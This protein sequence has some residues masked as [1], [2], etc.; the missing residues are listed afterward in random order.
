MTA[1][2]DTTKLIAQAGEHKTMCYSFVPLPACKMCGSEE[3]DFLGLRLNRR[4]GMNPRRAEGIA[5]S[6]K[7]CSNCGLIYP[8]P[9]PI[10][11]TIADHYGSPPEEYWAEEYLSS[12]DDFYSGEIAAA[13]ELINFVPGMSCLDVGAGMGKGMAAFTNAGFDVFGLEPS[14]PFYRRAIERATTPENRLLLGGI[15]DAAYPAQSFD[16]ISFSAVLEHLYD[17]AGSIERAME[18]LKPRGIIYAEVP[19]A[20]YLFAKLIN[21]YFRLRGTNYVTNCSPM[22]SPFHIYEFTLR[23]FEEH[24]RRAGYQAVRHT[25]DP[26][27]N[28][29]IPRPATPFLNWLMARK[30]T[31]LNLRVWLRKI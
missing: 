21:L 17:P 25:I 16:Y 10:P 28:P 3:R 2:C 31:G 18:W 11:A 20:R 19:N 12:D 26:G 7:R 5:T 15:E 4:Q 9:M 1:P 29:M 30:Q 13:K 14:E 6:I 23:S 8:D 27:G 22:H 24:G